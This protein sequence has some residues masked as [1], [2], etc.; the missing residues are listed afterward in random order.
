MS[1]FIRIKDLR[2]L[3]RDISRLG[4]QR[5]SADEFQ[6]YR[7][8]ENLPAIDPAE[9][10]ER[11]KIKFDG[12]DHRCS[13]DRIPHWDCPQCSFNNGIISFLAALERKREEQEES[14]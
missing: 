5:S 3:K 2:K 14:E 11:L 10:A 1:K 4:L 6:F 13:R 9:I 7:E 12:S 8:V